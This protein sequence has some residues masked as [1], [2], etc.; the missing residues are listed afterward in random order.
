MSALRIEEL[1]LKDFRCFESLTLRFDPALTVIFAENGGGKTTILTALAM[2]LSMLQPKRDPRLELD[3]LRD[4]RRLPSE[5][6]LWEQVPTCGLG[7]I[8]TIASREKMSWSATASSRSSD[9]ATNVSGAVTDA[10][11]ASR[12]VGAPWPLIAWYGPARFAVKPSR[13]GNALTF[14]ER[15]DGYDGA[16]DPLTSD[17]AL[18]EWLRVETEADSL[19]QRRKQPLRGFDAAVYDA[20]RRAVPELDEVWFEPSLKVPCVRFRSGRV[21]TWDDLSDGYHVFLGVVGDIARRVML[22]NAAEGAT[23]PLEV[24]GVVMIDEID[25]HLHPRWQR[26]VLDGLRRA[27]RKLQ[28]VVSTH[29]PQTLSSVRNDQVRRLRD[30]KLVERVVHVEGRDSNAILRDEFDTDDR[31]DDGRLLL[32]AMYKTFEEGDVDGARA[33]LA[34]L[35]RMWGENDPEVIRAEGLLDEEG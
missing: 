30:A 3:G 14:S 6:G 24:E 20:M 28:F 26:T 4:A 2:A 1:F 10:V 31:D 32:T 13:E 7:C 8:A 25:L 23:A 19:R 17:A 15:W 5:T 12:E 21:S 34:A 18:I 29:S 9:G 35:K 11:S 33:K 16:L 27:F 22:L